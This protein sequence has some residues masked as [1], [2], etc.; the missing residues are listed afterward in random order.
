MLTA[1]RA[2]QISEE[3]PSQNHRQMCF[4][5]FFAGAPDEQV[6]STANCRDFRAARARVGIKRAKSGA[7]FGVTAHLL[8]GNASNVVAYRV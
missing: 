7:A 4:F 6:P 5:L 2:G 3:L 8:F 1:V